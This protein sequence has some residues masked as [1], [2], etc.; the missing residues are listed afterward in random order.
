MA[1]Q[2]ITVAVQIDGL[3]TTLRAFRELPKDASA[4]LREESL[5]LAETL[6]AKAKID[7]IADAAPQSPLVATTVKAV[8]DRVPVIQAGGS[9]RLGRN[10]APAWKLLFG[11]MFGSNAY[12]QFHRPHAGQDAYWFFPVVE[13]NAAEIGRAWNKVAGEIARDFSQGG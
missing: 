8:R 13:R 5:K 3:R 10:R 9:K 4:R 11:S 1:K 6:A 2:A 12:R 7:G